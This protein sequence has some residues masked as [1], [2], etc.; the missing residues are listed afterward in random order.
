MK[1]IRATIT[2]EIIDRGQRCKAAFC[3]IS[4]A[5]KEWGLLEKQRHPRATG[6]NCIELRCV[7]TDAQSIRVTSVRE[8]LRYVWMT[9]P[10]LQRFLRD[11]DEGKPVEPFSFNLYTDRAVT[12]LDVGQR[13]RSVAERNQALKSNAKIGRNSNTGRASS[14][15]RPAIHSRIA[16]MRS[17]VYGLR[18][19]V[20]VSGLVALSA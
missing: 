4:E 12:I 1:S 19:G 9:P 6:N 18:S 17:N 20:R 8:G 3:A 10:R 11:Y 13:N 14:I 7:Q 2:Q 16:P 5:I 15:S